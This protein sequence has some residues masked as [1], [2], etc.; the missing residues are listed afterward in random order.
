MELLEFMPILE[1]L[2]KVPDVRQIL[3]QIVSENKINQA[4]AHEILNKF[5]KTQKPNP[6]ESI[7]TP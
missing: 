3:P 1:K 6:E 7:M 5:L 2:S 4:K